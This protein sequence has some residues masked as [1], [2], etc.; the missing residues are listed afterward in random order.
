MT[1]TSHT[2]Q[3][4]SFHRL[5]GVRLLASGYLA[6]ALLQLTILVLLFP[7]FLSVNAVFS[8]GVPRVII[9]AACLWIGQGLWAQARRAWWGAQLLQCLSIVAIG[10]GLLSVG[11]LGR[12]VLVLIPA[13]ASV[14]LLLPHVRTI[15]RTATQ[16]QP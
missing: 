6:F 7:A 9:S 15:F 2:S 14:Y 10:S 1:S 16:P 5:L 4:G 8:W 12:V 11:M 13:S 3:A